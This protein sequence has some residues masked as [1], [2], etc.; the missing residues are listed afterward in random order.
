MR[1]C[2]KVPRGAVMMMRSNWKESEQVVRVILELGESEVVMEVMGV[3]RRMQFA[4]I[5][6]L[7]SV[8]MVDL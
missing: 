8:S 3:L 4:S 7:E 6:G 2:F 1:F 5:A